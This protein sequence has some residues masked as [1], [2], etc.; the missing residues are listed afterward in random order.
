M[1]AHEQARVADSDEIRTTKAM[2][3]QAAS[4]AKMI[5]RASRRMER[6]RVCMTEG[7][8]RVFRVVREVRVVAGESL[9]IVA[10]IICWSI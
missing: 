3:S 2:N 8:F 5:Q 10:I 7:P 6:I 9:G 4:A 1:A